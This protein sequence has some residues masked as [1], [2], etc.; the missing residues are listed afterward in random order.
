MK[1][2]FL[3]LA[4]AFNV[5]A[6]AIFKGISQKPHTVSWAA[7]FSVGLVLGALNLLC[8]TFALRELDLGLAYPIFAGGT[9]ALIVLT[10]VWLFG[11]RFTQTN[12]AGAALVIAG[13]A[14]LTR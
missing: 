5:A 10:S 14:L 7:L 13:V 12:F 1:Y 4:V 2:A 11:E 9:I 3:A 8:F 6:Y